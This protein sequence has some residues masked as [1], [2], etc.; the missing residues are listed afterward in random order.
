MSKRGMRL[1]LAVAISALSVLFDA[2][3]AAAQSTDP[4]VAA[5]K[6]AHIFVRAGSR[7]N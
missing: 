7:T 6:D 2:G 4:F 1:G 5:A 3:L